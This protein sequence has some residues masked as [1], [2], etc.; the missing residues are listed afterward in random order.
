M[1]LSKYLYPFLTLILALCLWFILSTYYLPE[2]FLPSPVKVARAIVVGFTNETLLLQT[3]ITFQESIFGFLV[4]LFLSF[5]IGL[6][7]FSF[8]PLK[9]ATYPFLIAFQTTPLIAIAPIL[10]IWFG[11]GLESK[12][13]MASIVSFFPMVVAVITGFSS[14][15][16]DYM[17]LFKAFKASKFQ[18]FRKLT[19]PNSL[20]FIFAGMK[21]AIVVSIIGAIVGE[22]VG[23]T[24]G[25]GYYILVKE[26]VMAV[27][28]VFGAL[29][30]L[31]LLGILNFS[32]ISVVERK[33]L[34]WK[35]R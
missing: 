24:G 31:M 9:E 2:Y 28:S 13:I 5:G 20:P 17:E 33:V 32:I 23:S 35:N 12:I 16:Q 18:T 3:W 1:R 8:K 11:F 30:I 4:T 15:K 6:L 19:F 25:L 7:V 10:L 26:Q 29:I 21:V 22:F 34:F 14:T 27:P